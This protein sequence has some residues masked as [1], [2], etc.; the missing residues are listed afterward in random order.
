MGNDSKD[1]HLENFKEYMHRNKTILQFDYSEGEGFYISEKLN[2]INFAKSYVISADYLIEA[3][4]DDEME[5]IIVW[6]VL[7]LYRQAIE[8]F[9]K[10]ALQNLQEKAVGHDIS[11]LYSLLESKLLTFAEE[12]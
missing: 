5:P 11:N 1:S 8:L 7:Y 4:K 3:S 10:Q 2:P 6:P 12:Y 9:L